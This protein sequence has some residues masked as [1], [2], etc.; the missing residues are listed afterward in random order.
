MKNISNMQQEEEIHMESGLDERKF[1]ASTWFG[2][3]C[4]DLQSTFEKLED[5]ASDGDESSHGQPAGRFK[6]KEWQRQSSGD[7]DGGG[8]V[9]SMMHGRLFEKVGVHISTVY[10]KLPR[11]LKESLPVSCEDSLFWAS[12]ISLIAHMRNPHIPAVHMNTRMMTTS[13]YWF[14]GGADLTPMLRDRRNQNDP[15]SI[16]FHAAM[17]KACD[18]HTVAD[19]QCYK[20]RCDNYF[21]LPHRGEARGIG[22]IF[23]DQLNSGDWEAD[24]A[25]TQEVGRAFLHIYPQLVRRNMTQSW[26]RAEREEQLTF[27]GRYAE[28]NLLYDRGTAFGLQTGGN[29]ESIL[30][31]LPPL[32]RWP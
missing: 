13:Q 24:F 7:S 8:G 31:S 15:D 18:A 4:R 20:T 23:Y 6:R 19:Y 12:G 27:R 28:F 11:Q 14:G 25:F 22:G 29:I 30:S 9:M 2:E 3:L 5:E 1:R 17:K 10:G 32:A 26:T 21:F 16:D